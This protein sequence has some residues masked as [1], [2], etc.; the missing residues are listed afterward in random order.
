MP[1]KTEKHRPPL[2]AIRHKCL[3]C[4]G[5]SHS[6]IRDC[7]S[8]DCALHPYRFGK[9]PYRKP[10]T[11]AL[12]ETQRNSLKER[13]EKARAA[14]GSKKVSSEISDYELDNAF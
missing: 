11:V 8:E 6:Q 2:K 13:L 1:E 5:N 9:N 10:R 3:D 4:M 7:P 14:R 12:T